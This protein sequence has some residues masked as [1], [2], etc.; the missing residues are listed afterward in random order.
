MG[1]PGP[2]VVYTCA[3]C[4]EQFHPTS[5]RQKCCGKLIKKPCAICGKLFDSKCTTS[6]KTMTCSTECNS[7]YIKQRQLEYGSKLTYKCRWCG[8]EFHPRYKRDV[9]CYEKHYQTCECCG[10]Q[11]E[12]DVRKQQDTKT[13]SDE[14]RYKLAL[15]HRD[16]EAEHKAQVKYFMETYGV[17][18]PMKV[19]EFVE[20]LKATNRKKYGTDWYLQSED[21]K[22]KTFLAS[23]EKYGVPHFLSSSEIIDK[24]KQTLLD[25]YNVT[26]VFQL[27]STKQKTKNTLLET[28]GVEYITQSPEIRDKIEQ[29]NIKKYGV[30]YPTMLPEIQE[31]QKNTNIAR[32]GVISKNQSH[33]VN[34]ED[35]YSFIADPA[36]YIQDNYET[37]PTYT[38]LALKFNVSLGTISEYIQKFDAHRYIRKSKSKLEETIMQYIRDL[39]PETSIIQN[40]R[41][42]IENNELDIYIP[43][44]KFAIECDPICSHN[45][46]G[47]ALFDSEV[48]PPNYHENKSMKCRNNG[49]DLLHIFGYD[50]YTKPEVVKSMIANRLNK[51]SSEL[52]NVELTDCNILDM[53]KFIDTNS[54]ELEKHSDYCISIKS[55][56]VQIGCILFDLNSKKLNIKQFVTKIGYDEHNLFKIAIDYLIDRY[57]LSKLTFK[58]NDAYLQGYACNQL[59]FHILQHTPPEVHKISKQDCWNAENY[60]INTEYVEVYDSGYTIWELNV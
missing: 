43:D 20:N 48:T 21:C 19:P 12:I 15:S 26:N 59:G 9:Y 60:H 52:D 4:G 8:K 57:K 45:S 44:F 42:I 54:L 1:R 27:E 5:A 40:S 47:P 56:D 35:W 58:T 51:N 7:K 24:R 16:F 22:Y 6:E 14:C 38:E 39:L 30:T 36:K 41:S 11:F 2:N 17:D 29:N 32:Y 55:R 50:W 3:I 53:S 28:R 31:K 18:N 10:K 34:I 46:T 13:C 49:I 23:L 33:I 25:Q 37:Y